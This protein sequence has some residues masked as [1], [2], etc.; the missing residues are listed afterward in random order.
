MKHWSTLLLVGGLGTGILQAHEVLVHK[1]ITRKAISFLSSKLTAES[2]KPFRDCLGIIEAALLPGVADEDDG[3]GNRF[4]FHF[5]PPLRNSISFIYV[6]SSCSA[7]EWGFSSDPLVNIPSP[8]LSRPCS[9][10]QPFDYNTYWPLQL[11]ES[12]VTL[13]N[14]HT[15]GAAVAAASSSDLAKRIEGWKHLGYVLHLLQDM[16]SPAHVRSDGHPPGNSDPVE[17]PVSPASARVP[18]TPVGRD[19]IRLPSAPDYFRTLQGWT[20]RRFYSADT[21]FRQPDDSGYNLAGPSYSLID[22]KSGLIYDQEGRRIAQLGRLGRLAAQLGLLD[23]TG[24]TITEEIANEQWKELGPEAVLYSASLIYKFYEEVDKKLPCGPMTCVE[25]AGVI[26]PPTSPSTPNHFDWVKEND[27][28]SIHFL[29]DVTASQKITPVFF[30]P[31]TL[32]LQ[33]GS[34][35]FSSVDRMVSRW[36]VTN[37]S[38]RDSCRYYLGSTLVPNGNSATADPRYDFDACFSLTQQEAVKYQALPLP[39]DFSIFKPPYSLPILGDLNF[40][41]LQGTGLLTMRISTIDGY[42]TYFGPCR[43][44]WQP[45]R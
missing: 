8:F 34:R 9:H 12:E 16:T 27:P 30:I 23:L 6:Q 26:G 44:P 7:L 37:G 20:Q 1:A 29:A 40:H 35:R 19:L 45:E 39:Q 42:S 21:V 32:E 31:G 33:L 38:F 14:E 36:D 10:N 11:I 13:Q 5:D 28:V 18:G 2:D 41:L 4:M 25:I 43:T 3:P 15:W 22:L 24:A 17:N